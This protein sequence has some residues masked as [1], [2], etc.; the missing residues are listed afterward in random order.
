VLISDFGVDGSDKGLRRLCT[1]I[2]S[3]LAIDCGMSREIDGE[4][5]R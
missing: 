4:S 2:L 5:K 3:A 1:G